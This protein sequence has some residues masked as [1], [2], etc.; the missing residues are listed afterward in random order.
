ML[1]MS[2][3]SQV[4]QWDSSQ[5]RGTES[6][7][8]YRALPRRQGLRSFGRGLLLLSRR[9]SGSRGTHS[10]HRYSLVRW[11]WQGVTWRVVVYHT[12]TWCR[13][14]MSNRHH[15]PSRHILWRRRR[16]RCSTGCPDSSLCSCR[17][18]CTSILRGRPAG[19]DI[20]ECISVTLHNQPN[21]SRSASPVQI[22]TQDFKRMHTYR[23]SPESSRISTSQLGGGSLPMTADWV[24][25]LS[26]VECWC[27]ISR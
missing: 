15:D 22:C 13:V 1:L 8:P 4:G 3:Q 19:L 23:P 10:G 11:L 5:D 7:S 24:L 21:I 18:L 14:E 17:C 25:R 27:L 16:W 20:T 12:S 26:V 6:R 9:R 2:L